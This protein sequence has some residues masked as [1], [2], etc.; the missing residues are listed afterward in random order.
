MPKG[1]SLLQTSMWA[2]FKENE[3]WLTHNLGDIS[4]LEKK[5]PF[6]KTFLYTPEVAWR[7]ISP[8]GGLPQFLENIKKIAKN[9]SSIFFRLEI[10]NDFDTKIIEKLKQNGF[11]KAFEEIQPEW[12][13]IIDLSRSEEEILA[14]M[15]QKGRYN[16]RVAQKHNVM[17]E[18]SQNINDFYQIFLQTA[19]RDGFEIRHKQYFEKL[20]EIFGPNEIAELW[21]AKY[22]GETIAAVIATFY[23]GAACYIYGAS[24]NE[25]R[26]LM[27]P[28]LLHWQVIRRAKE[29]DCQSYDLL[30]IAPAIL[31]ES[32]REGVENHK[33]AGITRFKEQFGGRKVQIVG[34]WD[35]IYKPGW[36]WLF[37]KAESFRRK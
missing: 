36:Y 8:I 16:I 25:F 10:L 18:K 37:K 30:A 1:K 2:N 24:S 27:A 28:Y 3:G 34:S 17:I 15:K 9:S 32:R 7:A 29:K 23:E 20:F 35:L 26:N 14:Q 19:K 6:S 31:A 11:I 21:L 33:Y 12:R 5:L 4:I 13:Q 22:N